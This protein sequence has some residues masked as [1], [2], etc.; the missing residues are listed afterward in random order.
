MAPSSFLMKRWLSH[1]L[2]WNGD[3]IIISNEMVAPSSFLMKWWLSYHFSWNGA[4]V[5]ISHEMVAQAQFLMK[6]WL[7]HHLSW[8][9][10]SVIISH[11][12]VAQSF[13]LIKRWLSYHLLWNGG[14]AIHLSWIGGSVIISHEMVAQSFFILQITSL[15]NHYSRPI[16]NLT[17]LPMLHHPIHHVTSPDLPS[18]LAVPTTETKKILYVSDIHLMRINLVRVEEEQ[19]KPL[20]FRRIRLTL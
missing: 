2:S 17:V 12:M 11:E 20:S 8:N 9:G 10:G 5:I 13:F 15:T 6:W 14:S 18:S 4:S 16:R 19:R 7:N 1:N 3:S